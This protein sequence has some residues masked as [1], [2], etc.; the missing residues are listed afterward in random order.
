MVGGRSSRLG[1]ALRH[2]AVARVR[3]VRFGLLRG[4]NTRFA[5]L[6]VN[7]RAGA[8]ALRRVR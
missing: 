8:Y 7:A 5:V 2:K 3:S 1:R 4:D 6:L